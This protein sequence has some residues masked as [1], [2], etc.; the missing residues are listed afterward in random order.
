MDKDTIHSLNEV[1]SYLYGDE[2]RHW[3]E[4][5]QPEAHIYHDVAKL[6]DWFKRE[7][8]RPARADA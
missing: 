4:L 8:N 6:A 7:V 3:E 1:V 2:R 5:G